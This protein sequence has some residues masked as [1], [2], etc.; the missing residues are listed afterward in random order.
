M[1]IF[2]I[3]KKDFKVESLGGGE[4]ARAVA[5][6]F[7]FCVIDF[8]FSA[9]TSDPYGL[10]YFLRHFNENCNY[11]RKFLGLRDCARFSLR[12]LDGFQRGAPSY[13]TGYAGI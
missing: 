9:R 12:D 1:E 5:M 2:K 7:V 13:S 6:C 8:V 3:I 4:E 11:K 10:P